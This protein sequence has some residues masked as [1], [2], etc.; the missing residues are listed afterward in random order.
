MADQRPRL[1]R[2]FRR[3]RHCRL[4]TGFLDDALRAI[5][6]QPLA[7]GHEHRKRFGEFR[8]Q[9]LPRRRRQV[10]AAQQRLPDRGQRAEAFGNPVDG[11]LRHIG[12]RILNQGQAGFRSA[13]F[14]NRSGDRTRQP[15]AACNRG[16]HF[17]VAAGNELHQIGVDEQRRVFQHDRSNFSLVAGERMNDGRRCVRAIRQPFGQRAAHHRRRIVKEH[18]H[19]AFGGGAVVR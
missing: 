10:R 6:L 1:A 18:Q 14:R 4:L 3:N 8:H 9:R 13:N 12:F 15:H 2:H 17:R 19:G 11:E 7:R 16:L 5:G